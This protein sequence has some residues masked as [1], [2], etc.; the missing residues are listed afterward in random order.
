MAS[1]RGIYLGAVLFLPGEGRSDGIALA[2]P[3]LVWQMGQ[4]N[5]LVEPVRIF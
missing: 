3:H 2:Q 1:L 4:M 5:V